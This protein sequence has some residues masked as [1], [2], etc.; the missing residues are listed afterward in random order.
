MYEYYL[1]PSYWICFQCISIQALPLGWHQKWFET[2]E[3]ASL[4]E[5]LI[6]GGTVW[7]FLL[8][9]RMNDSQLALYI[10]WIHFLVS[11]HFLIP[12][13]SLVIVHIFLVWPVLHWRWPPARLRGNNSPTQWP[14]CTILLV[15]IH[16]QN[17][18]VP[19][20]LRYTMFLLTYFLTWYKELL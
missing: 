19:P 12:T 7:A 5:K 8:F 16:C 20:A 1:F 14:F 4:G 10:Q 18:Q 3:E 13:I 17:T 15:R 2:K 11:I 6:S 9:L